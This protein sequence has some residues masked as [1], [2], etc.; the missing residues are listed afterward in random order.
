MSSGS[1]DA[2]PRW[3][4]SAIYG[5]VD[6]Q[7]YR[8]D[9]ENLK[10][11]VA[12]Y[13]A[14]VSDDEHRLS[15]A[16]GWLSGVVE[17]INNLLDT[18][19]NLDSYL[20]A[21]YSTDT[22]NSALVRELDSLQEILRPVHS[23]RAEFRTRLVT[24]GSELLELARSDERLIPYRYFLEEERY[25][26]DHQLSPAEE[27]LAADLS[28]PGPDAWNRLQ[29]TI[30]ST[31]A[32]DWEDGERKTIVDLRGMAHDPNR[33]VRKRA[34]EREIAA[35]QSM[36][37]PLA[38]ALNGVKG[39][40]VILDRR[41]GYA[42]SLEQAIV[43]SRISRDSLD[44]LIGEMES[45]LPTFRR[46]LTAKASMLGVH[47]L[48]FYDLFAPVGRSQGS[49]SFP[50]AQEFIVKQF[51][52]FSAELAEFAQQAFSRSWI[53]AEPRDAKVGGGYCI[54][55]PLAGESRI[56]CNFDGSFASV[57]TVAHEL[58]HAYHHH[59]LKDAP[60]VHRDYPM[61]LAETA[62][63]FCETLAF[64]GGLA[65]ANGPH[66]LY[67]I[68]QSLQ[69]STQLI[70]DILSR[71]RF[72]TMLFDRRSN[73]V[74]GA[75][76]LCELMR[77]AQLETYGDAL[78]SDA[79]HPYMWA[80]KPHYYNHDRPFY[81]FP[82]A[83]GQLFGLALYA[84]YQNGAPSFSERYREMLESTARASAVEV[85]GRAGAD[86]TSPEFWREGIKMIETRVD[87]FEELAASMRR[88]VQ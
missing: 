63:I 66:E 36:E 46:Y 28:L 54:S 64:S 14:R 78:D 4:L 1:T 85:T 35:W 7:G 17:T 60:A 43:Q 3:S 9:R 68:E 88:D 70:V 74:L 62:S 23:T 72:E 2:T 86:I 81:N 13:A 34:Y 38:A 30:S 20:Y 50:E 15:D 44:A 27:D 39:F 83:F 16:A 5:G 11:L 22:T 76:E 53:D 31:L 79:L 41:R 73:G 52:E 40:A 6:S 21:A 18:H 87:R 67:V 77:H 48:A 84:Q 49:W 61:T 51:S 19:E 71:F 69:D 65:Q 80:V 25:Y 59:V 82:Y 29:E 42:Q 56:L 10:R 26:A 12:Q 37:G 57:G 45:S 58:G 55:F 75:D 33:D 24:L 47:K 32:V 8:G